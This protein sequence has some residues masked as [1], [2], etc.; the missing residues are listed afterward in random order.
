MN[1]TVEDV[2]VIADFQ[3]AR[4]EFEAAYCDAVLD[5]T[6]GNIS[7]AARLAKKDRNDFK[8]LMKRAGVT[9]DDYRYQVS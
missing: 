6:G 9:A 4:K 8:A 5:E 2:G 3:T 1:I 7:R